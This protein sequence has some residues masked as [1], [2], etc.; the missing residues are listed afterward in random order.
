MKKIVHPDRWLFRYAVF[1]ALCTWGLVCLGGLVTSKGVGMAVPDWPTSYGYNMFALPIST[2][3]TGG[4]FDEHTHRLW[5][6]TVGL[7]VVALVRFLGGAESRKALLAIGTGEIALGL[8]MLGFGADWRGAGHFLTGIGGVVLLAG[9]A[10]WRNVPADRSVVRLGWAAFWLVQIQ[11]LLGGLRVVLDKN[12]FAGSTLGT[13]FGVIHG[14]LG[15]AFLVLLCAVALK[16]S[17]LWRRFGGVPRIPSGLRP[18]LTAGL[19]LSV[20]QLVLGALMRHQHAGLAIHDFPLAYG[21]LWPATD[22]ASLTVY[23]QHRAEEMEVT[24]FQIHLQMWHRLGGVATLIAIAGACFGSWRAMG[25]ASTWGKLALC[26][27]LLI[28]VQATL[29]IMTIVMNKPADVATAHVAVGA[30]SLA[31][32]SLLFLIAHRSAARGCEEISVSM[33]AAVPAVTH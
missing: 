26:W 14:C 6:S 1:V 30:A 4:V 20:C 2:W 22:A 18:W 28:A 3:F 16:L 24:A 32:G 17:P 10:S 11:G 13:T 9:A 19:S 25:L 12:V 7:L 27:F 33:P 15:Q 21:Q 5:A 23:N 8:G 29:G 31:T